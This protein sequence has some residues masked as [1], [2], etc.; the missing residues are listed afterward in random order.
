MASSRGALVTVGQL[1]CYDQAKQLVLSTGL[2]SDNVFTHFLASFIAGGCA[3]FLCQPLDVLKTRL[4]NSQGEYRVRSPSCPLCALASASLHLLIPLHLTPGCCSLC[5]GNCQARPPR[6][7]QGTDLGVRGGGVWGDWLGAE[8]KVQNSSGAGAFQ[9]STSG[10]WPSSGLALERCEPR[11]L[12]GLQP[13]SGHRGSCP[14]APVGSPNGRAG[15]G[16]G[17]PALLGCDRPADTGQFLGPTCPGLVQSPCVRSL[18]WEGP[19]KGVSHPRFLPAAACQAFALLQPVCSSSPGSVQP[20]SEPGA[21][22]S[23]PGFY[24]DPAYVAVMPTLMCL[25]AEGLVHDAELCVHSDGCGA[26][27]TAVAARAACPASRAPPRACKLVQLP[28]LG[29]WAPSALAGKPGASWAHADSPRS[30]CSLPGLRSCCCPAHSSHHPHLSLLGT[31]TQTFW[32]QS[33]HLSRRERP[34]LAPGG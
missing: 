28:G 12:L 3:T 1:A 17:A 10:I 22:G 30:R 33:D 11:P 25:G 34:C 24:R 23:D 4:M 29:Y 26:S 2:L 6:L 20:P 13:G 21:A 5:H 32:D 9:A 14:A 18:S 15:R 16:S 8:V 7:L 19:C 27:L 31:A